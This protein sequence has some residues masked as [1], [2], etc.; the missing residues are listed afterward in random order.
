MTSA[1]NFITVCV[2]CLWHELTFLTIITWSQLPNLPPTAS[3]TFRLLP[4]VQ[5]TE[6]HNFI[7]SSCCDSAGSCRSDS[8]A[9][10][11]DSNSLGRLNEELSLG[12]GTSTATSTATSTGDSSSFCSCSSS[13]SSSDRCTTSTAGSEGCAVGLGLGF[14]A[15]L[16]GGV[17]KICSTTWWIINLSMWPNLDPF[18]VLCTTSELKMG[19]AISV[20]TN[21]NKSKQTN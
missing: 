7:P 3:T 19:E 14:G 12:A 11:S 6:R 18:A 9:S 1:E 4:S 8:S 20:A 2:W 15:T 13:S 16:G 10:S 21:P 5:K 17:S